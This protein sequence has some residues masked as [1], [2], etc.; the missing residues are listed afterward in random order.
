MFE[1][2]FQSTEKSLYDIIRS[3]FCQKILI[4]NWINFVRVNFEVNSDEK[5]LEKQQGICVTNKLFWTQFLAG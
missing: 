2:D 3:P 5:W 4:S 1:A